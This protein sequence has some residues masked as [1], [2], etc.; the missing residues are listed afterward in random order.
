MQCSLAPRIACILAAPATAAQPDPGRALVAGGDRRVAEV[1]AARA[2]QQVAADR[3]HVAQLHGRAEQQRLADERE[4][5]GDRRVRGELLH[6][7]EGSD[8]QRRRR[9]ARCPR[10]GSR[11]MSTRRLR[12][13]DAVL[14]HQVELRRAAGQVGRVRVVADDAGRPRRCRARACRRTA[15]SATRPAS[16]RPRGSRHGCSGTPRSG[17]GCRS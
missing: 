11:V 16:A 10:S 6:R 14:E 12:L 8:P 13:D 9:C 17:R 1:A 4:P 15:A 7:R 3:R 5:L 2:L